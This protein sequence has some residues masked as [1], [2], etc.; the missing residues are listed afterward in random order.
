M[1]KLLFIAGEEAGYHLRQ[2]TFY[3]TAL[4][5]PLLFAMLG[6]L[7]W[8]AEV[9]QEIPSPPVETIFTPTDR[10]TAPTGYVDY[11][12]LLQNVP[13]ENFR[14]FASEAEAQAALTQGHIESYYVIAADY[15]KSGTVTHYSSNPQLFTG[16]DELLKWLLYDNL[17]A[18]VPDPLLAA[19]LEEPVLVINQGPPPPTLNFIPPDLDL[20]RLFAASLLLGMF[21][22]LINVG[23]QLMLRGLQREAQAKVL[24]VLIAS[25]T[26]AEFIGGKILGLTALTLGQG[27]IIVLVGLLVYG[28]QGDGAATLPPAMLLLSLP[29]LLLGYLAYAGMVMSVAVLWPNFQESG[30][31]L[32]AMRLLALSPVFG[33]LFILPNS[34][35]S[36]AVLLTIS[37][38]TSPMLMPFRLL[39]SQ[40]VPL[41]QWALGVLG[42]AEWAALW[43]W[44]S[45]RLFRV[46]GLGTGRIVTLRT[47]RQ[48]LRG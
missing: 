1:G 14:P 36:L 44:L 46:Y 20:K 8:L 3:L 9:A 41:W 17:L 21:A 30:A 28:N 35:S 26:P 16:A 11:A 42:A 33:G 39:L 45:M 29:Y 31:L 18:Q 32:G 2:W 43:I 6:A 19:R 25:T 47:M 4:G 23:G 10:L 13:V 15:I 40:S 27:I 22:Y 38:L 12:G 37:P 48:M 5:M 7:P 24:E 34:D